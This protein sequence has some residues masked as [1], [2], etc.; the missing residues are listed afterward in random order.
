MNSRLYNELTAR[1]V[2]A[3]WHLSVQRKNGINVAL[4]RRFGFVRSLID[5]LIYL[6]IYCKLVHK[7][8]ENWIKTAQKQWNEQA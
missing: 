2:S 7:I 1:D 3:T 6:F 8:H 4:Y 5:W